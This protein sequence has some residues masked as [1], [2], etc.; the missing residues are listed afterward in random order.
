MRIIMLL[1]G[2]RYSQ[3]L[4]EIAPYSHRAGQH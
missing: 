2:E 3:F 4:L 1:R